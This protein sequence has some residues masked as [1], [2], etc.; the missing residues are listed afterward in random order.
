M[1]RL[2][3]IN[4]DACYYVIQIDE[5]DND[6]KDIAKIIILTVSMNINII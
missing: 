6:S 5:A 2:T 1:W 4:Y 3:I